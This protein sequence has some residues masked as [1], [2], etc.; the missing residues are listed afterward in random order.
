MTALGAAMTAGLTLPLAGGGVAAVAM[1]TQFNSG[2]ANISSLSD[3]ARSRVEQ[4]GPAVQNMAISVGQSTS[5]LNDG[6][7][8]SLIHI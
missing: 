3:E 4:W 6:L 8:L 7:Y 2:M 5:N 1:A